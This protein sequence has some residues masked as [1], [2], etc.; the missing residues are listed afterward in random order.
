METL[1]DRH[2]GRDFFGYNFRY[3]HDSKYSSR[4]PVI[5]IAIP[6]K[7][8]ITRVSKDQ[9]A[10]GK[11]RVTNDSG[12]T[13]DELAVSEWDDDENTKSEV[14]SSFYSNAVSPMNKTSIAPSFESGINGLNAAV[15]DLQPFS[16]NGIMS[17]SKIKKIPR[18]K[19]NSPSTSSK[20]S[21]SGY[22]SHSNDVYD[23]NKMAE[24][25]S[26]PWKALHYLGYKPSMRKYLKEI[27]T[28]MKKER[29]LSSDSNV[30]KDNC[31][32]AGKPLGMRLSINH[33]TPEL[34]LTNSGNSS[35]TLSGAKMSNLQNISVI[36]GIIEKRLIGG[37]RARNHMAMAT[38][39]NNNNLSS[40]KTKK[41]ANLAILSNY[42][43]VVSVPV[44]QKIS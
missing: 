9:P 41:K 22:G 28:P 4:C 15:R 17:R 34:K 35:K 8:T 23:R 3:R 40:F 18:K 14:D 7:H 5:D 36:H 20:N 32:V 21:S 10:S 24:K 2:L 29:S 44:G 16:R 6:E 31:L 26:A 1:V 43:T 19:L 30:D 13:I 11:S 33:K 38:R 39:L 12:Y 25:Q 37:Q 42:K 27:Y